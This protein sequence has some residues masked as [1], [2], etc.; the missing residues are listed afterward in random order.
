MDFYKR[1][2]VEDWT[3]EKLIEFYRDTLGQKDRK[4][5][6]DNIKKDLKKVKEK[7][8]DFDT[9]RKRQAQRIVDNWKVCFFLNK[10]EIYKLG[11]SCDSWSTVMNSSFDAQA[12]ASC[13]SWSTVMNSS[14]DAFF[15]CD[16]TK[17]SGDTGI[18]FEFNQIQ[19]QVLTT[20]NTVTIDNI[21][22]RRVTGKHLR[23]D[24]METTVDVT[25]LKHVEKL[26]CEFEIPQTKRPRNVPPMNLQ[27]EAI[28]D[29]E[30]TTS[31]KFQE[32]NTEK[33]GEVNSLDYSDTISTSD[34]KKAKTFDVSFDEYVGSG[35]NIQDKNDDI[36]E[37]S[38]DLEDENDEEIKFNLDDI[39][40][41]L[42]REPA[43]KWEVDNINVTDRFR[44]YQ[45]DILKKAEREGLD[46]KNI[47]E[48]LALSS[49]IVLTWPNPY[50]N[51]FTKREWAEVIKTSPYTI[52]NSPLSK[53]IST[54][55]HETICN[56][57]IGEDV[58]MIG[59][60]T[61]LSRD[62][63][64]SFNDLY[65]GLSMSPSKTM[66]KITEEEHCYMVKK[67]ARSSCVVDDITILNS[68]IKPL[69]CTPLQQK[70]DTVKTQLRARKSI[71][72]QLQ[73]KGGPAEAGIFL[74]MGEWM[75]TFFMDLKYDG[76][77]RSWLF[78]RTKLV[79]EKA[80]I[81]LAEFAISHI[82]ALE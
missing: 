37:S 47:Y 28:V 25:P 76:L 19:Q 16:W 71:N 3:C 18:K 2:A 14:F 22:N 9:S 63:A 67:K 6:L 69:K 46:Y 73:R 41:E 44:T 72:M 45:K 27:Q 17:M 74:N 64:C 61:K 60:K 35:V 21:D 29:A 55:L 80:S 65:N 12:S 30:L 26:P 1:R 62:V 66:E 56:N 31:D 48:L 7:N 58:Y 77:Y 4:K 42:Q 36:A 57:F 75:E 53:E 10:I 20:A 78:H 49:I 11:K 24:E 51:I 54:S 40:R 5:V 34:H 32:T 33:A 68:E 8:S 13:D 23:E 79:V 81:P 70:K 38:E 52:K 82:I 15:A 50:P 43:V 39:S 59:G